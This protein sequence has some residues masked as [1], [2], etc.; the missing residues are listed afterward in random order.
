MADR[1]S[2]PRHPPPAE[3]MTT[4]PP[5]L[6]KPALAAPTLEQFGQLPKLAKF[7]ITTSVLLLFYIYFFYPAFPT[8]TGKTLAGWTWAACNSYNGYLHGRLVPLFATTMLILAWRRNRTHPISPSY[9]GLI[10]LLI[11]F[12]FFYAGV[13]AI[14][15][16]YALFGTPFVII[17]LSHYLF[18]RKI[19]KATLFPAFF[20]WFSIPIP[21]LE[22]LISSKLAIP[23]VDIVYHTGRFLGMDLNRAGSTLSVQGATIEFSHG[24]LGIRHFMFLLM[25]A[26]LFA[27]YTQT[28]LW[29]KLLLFSAALPMIVLGNA[30]RLLLILFLVNIGSEDIARKTYHDWAGLLVIIPTTFLGLILLGVLLKRTLRPSASSEPPC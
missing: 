25:S 3:E 13:R 9:W 18:G 1:K 4:P 23:L 24:W 2:R 12:F 10:S 28:R 26:A 27:N 19:T 22:A 21:G 16:R 20:L 8:T 14:Q 7:L 17:G 29:K 15:P 30:A 6:P 5:T 11:G